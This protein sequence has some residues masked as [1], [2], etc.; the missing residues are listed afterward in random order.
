MR[1]CK[2]AETVPLLGTPAIA[3]PLIS[4]LLFFLLLSSRSN[5]PRL[6]SAMSYANHRPVTSVSC[7]VFM[8]QLL[9]LPGRPLT[10]DAIHGKEI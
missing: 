8:S 6:S 1:R 2:V 9:P 3:S 5:R 10:C 4:N 7:S